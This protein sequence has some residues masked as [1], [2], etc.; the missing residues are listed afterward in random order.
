MLMLLLIAFFVT[1]AG[2]S[3]PVWENS[4]YG[5]LQWGDSLK[6]QSYELIV[7]DFSA[8]ESDDERVLLEVYDGGSLLTSRALSMGESF[9]YNDSLRVVVDEISMGELEIEPFTKIRMQ[10][11]AA[12]EIEMRLVPNDDIY[13][14]G[15]DMKL[16]LVVENTAAVEALNL[17]I[18]ITSDPSFFSTDH[19]I[20]ELKPGEIWDEDRRTKAVEPI[21]LEQKAP[22]LPGPAEVTVRARADYLD[23]QKRPHHS[24]T[25]TTLRIAGPLQFHKDVEELQEYGKSYFVI[26][27]LRNIGNRTLNLKLADSAAQHFEADSTLKKE[28]QMPP[29]STEIISYK[30]EAKKPG[31]G[32]VIPAAE[33]SYSLGSRKYTVKSECP[34]VDVFGPYIEVQRM[35]QPSRVK[36]GED[37]KVST[38]IYNSG[39]KKS[40][41]KVEQAIPAGTKLVAGELNGSF[42]LAPEESRT[43]EIVLKCS[44][45]DEIKL[46]SAAVE[47]RDV[48]GR[49]FWAKSTSQ[50]IGVEKEELLGNLSATEIET[51]NVE[52][53][54]EAAKGSAEGPSGLLAVI[55]LGF[56][57][58]ISAIFSKYL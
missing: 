12:P 10:L 42:L 21:M 23:P 18:H 46:P 9:S 27:S 5:E 8:E 45:L 56:L 54:K 55:V 44:G 13:E 30:I 1:A 37:V 24:W 51:G 36:D 14:G 19:S 39:N 22:Y 43:L 58:L 47:Y 33:A 38:K 52:A 4:A 6:L 3:A 2:Q 26:N 28:L 7:A 35:V 41:V 34:V 31:K 40:L 57:G 49:T 48:Q 11:A 16:E 50:S 17:R 20:S 53:E 32:L 29:G 15:D 25:G